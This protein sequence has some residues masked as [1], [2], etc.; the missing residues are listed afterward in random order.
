MRRRLDRAQ[1]GEVHLQ[2][3]GALAQEV[4]VASSEGRSG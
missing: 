3:D 1:T 4:E 2:A